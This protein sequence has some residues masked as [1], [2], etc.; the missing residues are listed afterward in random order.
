M[1]LEK[2]FEEE[3]YG[4]KKGKSRGVTTIYSRKETG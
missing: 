4:N 1:G 3:R 2:V